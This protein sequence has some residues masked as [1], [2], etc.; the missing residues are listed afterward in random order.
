MSVAP[1]MAIC[2]ATEPRAGIGELGQ[3][4]QEEQQDLGV[5]QVDDQALDIKRAPV[6]R[7]P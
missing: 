3:E 5:E 1:R 2:R 4:G 7:L 6:L